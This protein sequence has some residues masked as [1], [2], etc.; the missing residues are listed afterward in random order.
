MMHVRLSV[1]V[2]VSALAVALG[3]QALARDLPP[4]KTVRAA[5]PELQGHVTDP[6]GSS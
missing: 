4:I 3:G 2:A 6:G 5:R 1:C